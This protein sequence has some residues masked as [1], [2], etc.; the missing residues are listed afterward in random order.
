MNI[1]IANG[2]TDDP[3]Y[4]HGT[5][6]NSSACSSCFNDDGVANLDVVFDYLISFYNENNISLDH[7]LV[8][9][10]GDDLRSGLNLGLSLVY[11]RR[12]CFNHVSELTSS[13]TS[14]E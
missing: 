8:K 6:P 12:Q 1:R 10:K 14:C 11:F 9:E 2:P 3:M 4:P 5:W 7:I 13:V